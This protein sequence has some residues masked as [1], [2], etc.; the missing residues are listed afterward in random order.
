MRP[1]RLLAL[2]LLTTAA[3]R[4][5]DAIQIAG[6]ISLEPGRTMVRLVNTTSGVAAWVAVGDSFSGYRVQS[7]NASAD[8]RSD[9]VTLTGNGPPLRLTLAVPR[10][11]SSTTRGG[12]PAAPPTG[13][14]PAA[15]TSAQG[16]PM[17]PTPAAPPPPPPGN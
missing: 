13:A 17:V 15:P 16:S 12:A 2:A 9:S 10:V 1:L 11:R 5:A 8:G 7:F 3:L 14:T 4:A 6:V